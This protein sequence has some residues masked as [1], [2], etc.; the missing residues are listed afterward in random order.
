MVIKGKY[1]QA[2]V[3]EL[4][5]GMTR[6]RIRTYT[7]IGGDRPHNVAEDALRAQKAGFSAVKMNATEELHYIDSYRKIDESIARIASIQEK[8]GGDLDITI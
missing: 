8:V 4:L 2:P 1:Y 5:G 6:D 3:H 7:W